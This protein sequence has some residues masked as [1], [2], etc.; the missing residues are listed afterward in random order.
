MKIISARSPIWANG[1]HTKIDLMIRFEEL[2]NEEHPF[3]ASPIDCEAHGRDIFN[4]A[5]A[6]EFGPIQDYAPP[7]PPTEEEQAIIVRAQ[8]DALL[9]QTDW[10]QAADIPQATKD[11]W[12]PYRQDLRDIPQ[13]VGFPFNVV[14]PVKP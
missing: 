8:R 5:Q 14:W 11:R 13:Q 2:P 10:T 4:R 7:P 3:T 6:G 9:A 12:A 1:E